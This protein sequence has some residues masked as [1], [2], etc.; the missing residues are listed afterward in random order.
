MDS[1]GRAA[2]LS[3]YAVAVGYPYEDLDD[4]QFER[5]V[6]ACSRKLFG[7]G[8]QS[9]AAGPDGGRDARFHGT[10]E[11]F[12]SAAGPWTGIT[13]IQAKHTNATNV[14]Y[15]DSNFSGTIQ[16]SVLSEE[17]K[18][19]KKLVD[20]GEVQNYLLFANRRLGGVTAPVITQRIAT[21]TGLDPSTIFLAGS[22]YLDDLL[23]F[24]PDIL[25]IARVDPI[26]SP[27]K[28]SSHEL[29]EVVLAL[30]IE[31]SAPLPPA[32]APLVDRVSFGEKNR[33]NNMSPEFADLLSKRYM[34]YTRQIEDFLAQPGNGESLRQYEAAVEEFQ[35]KIIAHRAE[36]QSFDKLF[37]Y[38]IELLIAR[39]GVLGR[40]KPL[41]RALV[42]YMYWHCD[43]GRSADVETEQTFAP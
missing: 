40:N 38:L 41:L 22:E 24:Y 32:D 15:S 14:H 4:S 27:L 25:Q 19:V 20:A 6:V 34:V 7:I 35:T 31:L 39:D 28:V 16:S 43:I 29:A 21:D 17:V 26:D 2:L 33:L 5:L 42:F 23:H 9:F 12:P 10:A 37:N 30:S 13:V 11:R 3:N 36:F 18:R 8:V 1:T